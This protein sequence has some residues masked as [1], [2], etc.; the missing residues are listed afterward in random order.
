[1][2]DLNGIEVVRDQA[3][4]WIMRQHDQTFSATD[5]SAFKEWLDID[6]LHK[7]VYLEVRSVW[8]ITG[9]TPSIEE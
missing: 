8:I 2:S 9:L 5:A 6:E 4:D 3:I 7:R 1:M